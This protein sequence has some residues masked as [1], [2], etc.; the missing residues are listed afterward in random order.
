MFAPGAE[1]GPV[2]RSP[3][4]PT[5]RRHQILSQLSAIRRRSRCAPT[6]VDA[7]GAR[8]SARKCCRR[9]S[10]HPFRTL[11]VVRRAKA[12]AGRGPPGWD[13]AA[14]EWCMASASA[15]I[16]NRFRNPREPAHRFVARRA[17]IPDPAVRRPRAR[18]VRHRDPRCAQ[19]VLEPSAARD[20]LSA[21]SVP[22]RWTIAA[23]RGLEKAFWLVNRRGRYHLEMRA[24]HVH[25]LERGVKRAS[26]PKRRRSIARRHE[27]AAKSL[28]L[29][30][31]RRRRCR[32][33]TEARR[34]ASVLQELGDT[35]AAS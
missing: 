33:F 23:S 30:T 15:P 4:R 10:R 24:A 17:E 25:D 28:K 12:L 16:E 8:S 20:R 13:F 7:P 31:S 3:R 27:A 22:H 35:R 5:R 9:G 29:T 2:V 11:F 32:R 18:S 34:S 14:L 19:L 1:A 6:A 26:S 21:G